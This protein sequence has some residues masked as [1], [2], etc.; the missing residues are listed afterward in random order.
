MYPTLQYITS[1]SP[2]LEISPVLPSCYLGEDFT[3][4]STKL[5]LEAQFQDE[6]YRAVYHTL[7]QKIFLTLEWGAYPTDGRLDFL[8]KQVK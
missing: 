3:T 7:G 5:P 2:H 8:L 1:P 4:G 6:M